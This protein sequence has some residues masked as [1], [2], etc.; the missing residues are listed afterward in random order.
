MS[1]DLRSFVAAYARAHPD[2]VIRIAEPVAIEYDVMASVL[3]IG[4]AHV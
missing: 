1:Q 2:E 4:R 3:E